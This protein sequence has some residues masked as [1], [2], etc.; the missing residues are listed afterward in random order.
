MDNTFGTIYRTTTFGES[1]SRGVGAVIDGCP[2][3]IE[4]SE[5]IIQKQL[6]RRKPGTSKLTTQRNESDT[7]VILSGV[8]NGL[9]LGTPIAVAVMNGD[10][11]PNDYKEFS[12]VPRPSHA[13]FT[14]K[15]KF[16]LSAS[17]GGGR[18]SAR[19]TVGRVISGAIAM[20]VLKKFDIEISAA[21]TQ[22]GEVKGSMAE[23][24]KE[25]EKAMSE[26]NSIGGIIKCV[27]KNLP[28][29][30]GN[31]VFDKIDALLAQAILS[32]P[33]VKGFEIGSGFSAGAMKGNEHND[34]FIMQNGRLKTA[35]NNSGG[36]Q[37]GITNGEDIVFNT[38]FKPTA[39]IGLAQETVGYDGKP[40]L[41]EGK[42][43]HD[44]CVAIR[45]VPVVEAMAA[46][47]IL[48]LLLRQKT[49]GIK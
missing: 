31:P 7:A 39:T 1:H 5:E 26:K 41:L 13:D 45:A 33:A 47:V 42:G 37:G 32:I 20:Q 19:E 16:G 46:I 2:P 9:T 21:V 22:I 27:C 25:V 43:R 11:R 6:D 34:L 28:A 3:N 30:L 14:Y 48:D 15:A 10:F 17:S 35:S 36:V 38:V 4:I 24:E 40:V 49:V 18:A 8:E 23:M 44:P 12:N 29:G